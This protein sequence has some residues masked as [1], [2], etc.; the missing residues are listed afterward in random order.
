[1]PKM[2]KTIV[3]CCHEGNNKHKIIVFVNP[4]EAVLLFSS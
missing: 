2:G 4:L 1:M 3:E